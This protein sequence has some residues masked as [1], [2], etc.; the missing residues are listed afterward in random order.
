MLRSHKV[1]LVSHCVLNQNAVVHPLA[2]SGGPFKAIAQ[3]LMDHDFGIVQLSC[4]EVLMYGMNRLPMTKTEYDTPDYKALCNKLAQRD[5]ELVQ[6]FL[7]GD[8][9]VVGIVG[10]DQSPSCSQINDQG[11]FKTA[12]NQFEALSNL[13]QIDIPETYAINTQ[14]AEDF[15]ERLKIWLSHL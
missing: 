14:S 7:D 15:H 5:F 13:P 6:R 8:M 9:T 4:P 10:I 2:R 3:V 1:I 12:L 11:H